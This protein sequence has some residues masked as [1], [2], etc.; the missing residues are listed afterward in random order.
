MVKSRWQKVV[1]CW[2]YL[3]MKKKIIIASLTILTIGVVVIIFVMNGN[4]RNRKIS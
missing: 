1:L 2:R 4:R 3:L